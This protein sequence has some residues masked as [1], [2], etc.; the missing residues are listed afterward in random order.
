MQTSPE[1]AYNNLK[2]LEQVDPVKS[3]HYREL[4]QAV[5][6]DPEISLRLRDAISDR[7]NQANHELTIESIVD[8]NSY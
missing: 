4:A 1:T 5:L 8:E 3:A 2:L 7:L 6:A